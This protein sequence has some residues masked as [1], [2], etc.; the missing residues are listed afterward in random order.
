MNDDLNI[1]VANCWS[2]ADSFTD[3]GYLS[4]T[5]IFIDK[6]ADEGYSIEEIK[7]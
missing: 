7:H 6:L 2:Y 3:L 5:N 4:K 1:A